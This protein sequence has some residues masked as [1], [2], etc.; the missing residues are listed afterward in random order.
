MPP[1]RRGRNLSH[2]NDDASGLFEAPLSA[3]SA[4]AFKHV[5]FSL[6]PRTART[7]RNCK[8]NKK[9]LLTRRLTRSLHEGKENTDSRKEGDRGCTPAVRGNLRKPRGGMKRLYDD[10]LHRIISV[11]RN[12]SHRDFP[13]EIS[14]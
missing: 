12:F 5:Q 2:E 14:T 6:H 4:S 9:H 7:A 13:T 3:P 8:R 11:N 1:V 10:L